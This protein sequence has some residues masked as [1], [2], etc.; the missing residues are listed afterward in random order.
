MKAGDGTP[1]ACGIAEDITDSK[2][3]EQE[4]LTHALR[5]RDALVREVHHRIKNSLQ[6]VVG[7]LQLHARERP[8]MEEPIRAA[9]ARVNSGAA[10][11]GLYAGGDG[12]GVRLC[13]V[14]DAIGAYERNLFPE[15]ELR[16]ERPGG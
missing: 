4:R 15:I 1:L 14:V 8:G 12:G 7:L 3:A 11:H 5:Q 13:D 6:G 2:R 9:I 10:V 16:I